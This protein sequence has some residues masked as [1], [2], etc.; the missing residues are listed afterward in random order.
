[1]ISLLYVICAFAQVNL[2]LQRALARDAKPHPPNHPA[3]HSH[4]STQLPSTHDNAHTSHRQNALFCSTQQHQRP[5]S[6]ASGHNPTSHG[7]SHYEASRSPEDPS[8]PIY[9]STEHPTS[10]PKEWPN[11]NHHTPR[12]EPGRVSHRAS[13]Q[14]RYDPPGS[15]PGAK[16]IS[17][18]HPVA[19]VY[20]SRPPPLLPHPGRVGGDAYGGGGT[21]RASEWG[22]PPTA[23][24]EEPQP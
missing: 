24:M 6:S 22:G 12:T 11:R 7:H 2:A 4:V 16:Q 3:K 8:Y 18:L 10:H 23:R 5:P 13:H 15:H 20:P 9:R 21:P 17:H 1:M 19:A 14:R